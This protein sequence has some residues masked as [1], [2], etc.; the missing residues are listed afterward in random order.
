M[1]FLATNIDGNL[2]LYN[3][4]H[5]R[6]IEA[7]GG[8][9]ILYAGTAAEPIT[10]A[11]FDTERA[12]RDEL[13]AIAGAIRSGATLAATGGLVW[14]SERGRLLTKE[15]LAQL[16]AEDAALIATREAAVQT[17]AGTRFT[18]RVETALNDFTEI[19]EHDPAAAKRA[20]EAVL[21]CGFGGEVNEA[22]R[23]AASLFLS[24]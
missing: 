9:L 12:A 11:C 18:Q 19:A 15:R 3:L 7:N 6:Q 14:S 1:A 20:A 10:V 23:R 22:R 21:R 8:D 17:E 13:A 24:R 4:D 2:T 16:R 5:V